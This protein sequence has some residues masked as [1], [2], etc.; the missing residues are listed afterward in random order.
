VAVPADALA[1]EDAGG[2]EPG[3]GREAAPA[4]AAERS[5]RL[6]LTGGPPAE[7]GGV[8]ERAAR[9]GGAQAAPETSE[10]AAD[11]DGEDT[12][13][14]LP[15]RRRKGLRPSPAP[16]PAAPGEPG[17]REAA[18]ERSLT[19]IRSMMSAFQSGSLRGRAQPLDGDGDGVRGARPGESSEG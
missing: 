7:A 1:A 2:A 8:E 6:V 17:G 13:K 9:E 10:A 11:G 3:G 18:A 12:Y 5:Q 19:E 16:A 4:Q 14:G 15:R